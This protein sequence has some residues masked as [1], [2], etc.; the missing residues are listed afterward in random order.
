MKAQRVD[1][2]A[3]AI[4]DKPGALAAKFKALAAAGVNLE[5]VIARRSP[6]KRG[7]GVV[8]VTPIKGPRQSGAA[9]AAGFKKTRSLHTVQLEGVNKRG[10]GAR[11]TQALADKGLNLRGLSAAAI[12]NRFVCHIALDTEADANK[13]M[14]ILRGL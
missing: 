4:K 7:T 1:T 5:F 8:F 10:Q 14:R 11:L 9:E 12:G 13:A 2:W 3:A 6:E